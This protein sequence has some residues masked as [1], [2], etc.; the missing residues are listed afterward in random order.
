MNDSELTIFLLAILPAEDA[1]FKKSKLP[2]SLKEIKNFSINTPEMI[3]KF[4]YDKKTR[5]NKFT[6]ILNNKIGES[7]IKNDVNVNHLIDFIDKE[8]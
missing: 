1:N 4:K 8:I 5:N 7:F 2:T 3:E 6:F